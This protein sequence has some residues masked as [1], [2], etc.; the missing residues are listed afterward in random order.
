MIERVMK[1]MRR[2]DGK[3][4]K[5]KIFFYENKNFLYD[6]WSNQVSLSILQSDGEEGGPRDKIF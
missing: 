6:F 4:W 2:P 1:V 3:V 5:N